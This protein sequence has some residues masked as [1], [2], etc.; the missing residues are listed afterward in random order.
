VI[1]KGPGGSDMEQYEIS[2]QYQY[3]L[4]LGFQNQY[5]NQNSSKKNSI[6]KSISKSRSILS[7]Y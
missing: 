4:K 2:V 7:K 3:F 6:S 5:Q 1:L